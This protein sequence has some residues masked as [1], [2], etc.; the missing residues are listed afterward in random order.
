MFK[1]FFGINIGATMALLQFFQPAI[2]FAT[3]NHS[4]M[5]AHVA[6]RAHSTLLREGAIVHH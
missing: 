2:W 6:G 1:D 3:V 4:V 5:A